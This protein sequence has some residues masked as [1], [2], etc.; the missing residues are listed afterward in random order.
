MT[1]IAVLGLGAMGARMARRLID[2]GHDVAVYNRTPARMAPLVAL[3]ARGAETPKDAV[4]DAEVVLTMLTD[5]DAARGVWL[6][7]ATGIVRGI[8]PDT[9]ALECSTVTPAWIA[10][11]DS[12]LNAL[13]VRLLDAPVAGSRPQADAG[14][15]IFVIGGPTEALERVR[16]ALAVLGG[17]VHHVGEIGA[18]AWMKLAVNSL[19][20]AQIGLVAELLG[21]MQKAGIAP[22]RAMAV[23]GELPVTSPAAKGVGG[24]IV[25]GK[26]EPLFP[27]DL[28]EKDLRYAVAAARAVDASLPTVDASRQSYADA[29]RAGH[30]DA[31]ISAIARLYVDG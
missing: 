6:D 17:A 3:G 29:Q 28:V 5:D 22:D 19:F 18:G 21:M 31:N 1:R 16:P 20:A 13:G 8:R 10:E 24:L 26:H 11:L 25:A 12:H 15:L 23:L 2:A 4:S 14:K 9:V 7:D 30:G 27:I